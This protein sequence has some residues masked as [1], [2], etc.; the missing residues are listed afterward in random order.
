MEND[1]KNVSA[2]SSDT[3]LISKNLYDSLAYLG[4]VD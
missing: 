3:V 2:P 4:I 1:G